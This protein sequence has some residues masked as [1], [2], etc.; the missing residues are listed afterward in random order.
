ML[1]ICAALSFVP[2][3]YFGRSSAKINNYNQ[4]DN[5]FSFTL[6]TS[7]RFDEVALSVEA[8]SVIPRGYKIAKTRS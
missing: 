2:S 4:L 6:T 1:E 3:G 7:S 8:V 5:F